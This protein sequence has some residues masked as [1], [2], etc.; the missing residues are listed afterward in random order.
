MFDAIK[1]LFK[2][3]E[4]VPAV[5]EASTPGPEVKYRAWVKIPDGR[6][7]YID[8]YKADGRFGV[9]PV[10]F[11]TGRHF[12][13]TSQHWT[14]EQRLKVPEELALKIG[15]IYAAGDD[16]IPAQYRDTL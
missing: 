11:D 7:G 12:P 1:G 16:E 5:G 15:D 3:P 6:V 14:N 10:D 8:H 13:N 2:K 9:R 4:F